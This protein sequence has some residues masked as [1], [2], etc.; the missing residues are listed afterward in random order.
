MKKTSK[1]FLFDPVQYNGFKG[2]CKKSGSGVT[3]AF[4]RFM[5]CCI[6]ADRLVYTEQASAALELEA[7]VMIDWLDKGRYFYRS[8]EGMELNV[9]GRLLWLLPRVRPELAEQIEAALKR[10]VKKE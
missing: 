5:K 4:E 6:E 10:S 9:S 8:T 2:V 7:K 3:G 1:S